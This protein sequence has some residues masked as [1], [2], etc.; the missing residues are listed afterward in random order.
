MTSTEVVQLLI[1]C[2]LHGS[3]TSIELLSHCLN[4]GLRSFKFC[5]DRH[6]LVILDDLSIEAIRHISNSSNC[7]ELCC[8]FIDGGDASVA[9]NA[10]ASILEHKA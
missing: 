5:S 10:L 6:L 4:A 7:L 2:L 9:I 8:A 1:V 3:R